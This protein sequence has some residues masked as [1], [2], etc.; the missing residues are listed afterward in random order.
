[1]DRRRYKSR[2][3]IPIFIETHCIKNK[4]FQ[5]LSTRRTEVSISDMGMHLIHSFHIQNINKFSNHVTS[6]DTGRFPEAS[7]LQDQSFEIK[8]FHS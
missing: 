2:H 3:L 5:F 1:M 4:K 8:T 7:F 6:I